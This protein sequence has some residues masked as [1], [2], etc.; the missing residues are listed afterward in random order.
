[1]NIKRITSLTAFLSFFIVLLTSII[2][3]IVPQ[4]RVAYWAD[5]RLWGLSKE[6]WGAIH[7]N[8]G[9]LF[10]LALLLHIY[11]SW[12][13][14][15]LYLK[16]KARKLKVF[17]REFNIAGIITLLFIL[18]TYFELPPFSTII[19]IGDGIKDAAAQKYGEPPYGHAELSSLKTFAQKMQIDLAQATASLEKAGYTVDSEE[20]TLQE[21]AR[22]NQVS[23]QELFQAMK[24]DNGKSSV[25]SARAQTLPENPVPGTG[26]LTLIDFCHQYNL[27]VKTIVRSLAGMQIKAEENM[28]IKKIA[29]ANQTSPTDLYEK[30]KSVAAD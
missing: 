18:G 2:L 14:I 22:L 8:V 11:Y 19:D 17:T 1:M 9:F 13:P 27:N 5:W 10:L 7:I 12:K 26:N 16:D 15:T 20:Q 21:L 29:E 3:Y 4:G 25:V 6:Q 24:A 30:I 28:T 23:P